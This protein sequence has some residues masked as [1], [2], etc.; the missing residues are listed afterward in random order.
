MPSRELP[1]PEA[2]ADKMSDPA[3]GVA[4]F[5]RAD[6]Q[7]ER[8][9][10]FLVVPQWTQADWE[11]LF[12]YARIVHVASGS[13]LIERDAAE[14]ALYFVASGLL[15]VTSV[16]GG[17]SL[18]VIAKVH[19]GSVVGELAF[20]DGKPRSAK[21]WAAADSQVHRLEYKDCQTF[22]DAHPRKACDLLFALG[23]LV[24]LR[25][26]RSQTRLAR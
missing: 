11:T 6:S 7:S 18:G 4:A 20:L 24:A 16:L 21:V 19:P 2:S 14:R 5:L 17:H 15:E 26:R 13:L 10:E 25:F 22:A 3:R 23:R 12:S 8:D 1:S 9:G